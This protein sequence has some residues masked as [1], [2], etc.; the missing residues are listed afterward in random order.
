MVMERKDVGDVIRMPHLRQ[1]VTV[2]TPL[3]F[4]PIIVVN[5]EWVAAPDQPVGKPRQ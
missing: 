1:A 4:I 2:V 5:G 3:R